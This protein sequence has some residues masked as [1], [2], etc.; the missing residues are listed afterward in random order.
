MKPAH[1]SAFGL[2]RGTATGA[3]VAGEDL[4]GSSLHLICLLM[5]HRLMV[6]G[7][8]VIY[9]RI[10]AASIELIVHCLHAVIA[11]MAVREEKMTA[12]TNLLVPCFL[13]HNGSCASLVY[14]VRAVLCLPRVL[15]G[16][17]AGGAGRGL[18]VG[19]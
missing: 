5:R 13:V 8:V 7:L 9:Y 14:G 12:T 10:R 6:N 17:L 15:M 19:F 1:L 2:F 4:L 18:G 3:A 16:R 11:N